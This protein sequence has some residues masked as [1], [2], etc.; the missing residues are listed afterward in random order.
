MEKLLSSIYYIIQNYPAK[1][2]RKNLSKLLYYAD[3]VFF[4]RHVDMITKE[5]YIR[6]EDGPE[7]INLNL[8]IVHLIGNGILTVEPDITA[9]SERID[10]FYLRTISQ[11]NSNL[12][13]EEIRILNKVLKAFKD[14]VKQEDKQYPNLYENY[15]ITPIYGE[16][17]FSEKTIN[18]KIHIFKKK[19][20]LTLSGKIFRV[21]FES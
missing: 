3:G 21:L 6:L 4:Q 9:I 8:A 12:E 2:D 5:K 19:S 15:V 16:I 7:L 18:T 11:M 14:G 20:L 17:I 13:K 1:L 10:K